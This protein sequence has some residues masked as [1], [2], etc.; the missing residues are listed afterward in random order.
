VTNAGRLVLY[1]QACDTRGIDTG[2]WL[3]CSA[4]EGR[5]LRR[6]PDGAQNNCKGEEIHRMR[7]FGTIGGE[8]VEAGEINKV[9]YE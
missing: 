3:G 7:P 1:A 2:H 6:R 9:R 4:P 8:I 5:A